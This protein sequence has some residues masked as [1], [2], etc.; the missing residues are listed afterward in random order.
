MWKSND[1]TTYLHRSPARGNHLGG[2]LE[3]G[4]GDL[5]AGDHAGDFVGAGGVVEEADLHFG[6]AGGLVFFN[7]E[8]LVG[9]G[10]DLR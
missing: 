6:A 1:T 4:F 2:V 5:C 7:D 9:E 3:A 8:V 10:G